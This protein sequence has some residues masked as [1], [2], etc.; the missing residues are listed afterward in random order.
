MKEKKESRTYTQAIHHHEGARQITHNSTTTA[1]SSI[2]T[3]TMLCTAIHSPARLYYNRLAKKYTSNRS[4]VI[5]Y[6]Y[7]VY[8]QTL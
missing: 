5:S 1:T 3:P 2:A 7:I 6:K 4:H 8:E